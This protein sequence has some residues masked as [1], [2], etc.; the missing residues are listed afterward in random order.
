MQK[1]EKYTV[2]INEFGKKIVKRDNEPILYFEYNEDFKEIAIKLD[3]D[4]LQIWIYKIVDNIYL[5]DLPHLDKKM[6]IRKVREEYYLHYDTIYQGK[7]E[8]IL[9]YNKVK[10]N[11]KTQS[12]KN[13][14]F[15]EHNGKVRFD[16]RL[17]L[18]DI[19]GDVIYHYI[20]FHGKVIDL[21]NKKVIIVT[22]VSLNLSYLTPTYRDVVKQV[23]YDEIFEDDEI[24]YY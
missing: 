4:P 15:E 12:W 20:N 17:V 9:D 14:Y 18:Y 23:T 5:I 2:E 16:K 21:G 10:Q 6:L 1:Q 13:E 8:L 11:I 22:N 24:I 3:S 7:I 19:L